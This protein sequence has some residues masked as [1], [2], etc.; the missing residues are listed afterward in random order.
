MPRTLV[1]W[2]WHSKQ[3]CSFMRCSCLSLGRT[4]ALVPTFS[5]MA[6]SSSISSLLTSVWAP[7]TV[8]S[9]SSI[10]LVCS[11]SLT[12]SHQQQLQLLFKPSLT[13]TLIPS[14]DKTKQ[15]AGSKKQ[16]KNTQTKALTLSICMTL[17]LASLTWSILCSSSCSLWYQLSCSWTHHKTQP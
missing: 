2:L 10:F 6:L 17:R 7:W 1:L 8:S 13:Y 16:T 5:L 15:Y 3:L 4:A 12:C 11:S 14:Q 9:R